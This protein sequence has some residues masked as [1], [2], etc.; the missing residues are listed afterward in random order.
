MKDLLKY[1]CPSLGGDAISD[2]ANNYKK[3]EHLKMTY[4]PEVSKES[5]MFINLKA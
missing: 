3:L 5:A 2:C 1:L 4:P